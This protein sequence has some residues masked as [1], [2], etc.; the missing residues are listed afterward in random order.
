MSRLSTGLTLL[1]LASAFP[2][3]AADVL[4]VLDTAVADS[5]R[6]PAILILTLDKDEEVVAVK[7]E[8]RALGYVRA[9]RPDGQRVDV[10]VHRIRS[11][12]DLDGEDWTRHVLEGREVVGDATGTPAPPPGR[13]S[14]LNPR[15]LPDAR[16]FPLLQ[17][18]L[19]ARVD[20]GSPLYETGSAYGLG[21]IG[22]MRNMN[23]RVA[24]GGGLY[25]GADDYRV[26]LGPKARIKYW[27]SQDVSVDFA[28]GI[29]L[30]GDDKWG[31]E[32]DFP[33]AVAE[34]S[35]SVHEVLLTAEVETVPIQEGDVRDH[36]TS[37]YMGG[38]L[39]G[40]PGVIG[41][42]LALV[43]FAL[44]ASALNGYSTMS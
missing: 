23:E 28:P 4:P 21:D 17:F 31:G 2:A 43:A 30:A 7:V 9:I 26:R 32:G 20:A 41:V 36:D 8:P 6:P 38:K 14:W 34:V 19:A 24:L 33:G 12:R 40:V 18:G 44:I 37:W 11:I 35:L 3:Y 5:A 13:G 1:L 16:W 15:P 29:L 42:T 39:A 27:I 25:V 22:V 10:P